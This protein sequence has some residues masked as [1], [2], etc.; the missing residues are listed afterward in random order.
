M[1]NHP[2]GTGPPA[3]RPA[4]PETDEAERAAKGDRPASLELH[5]RWLREAGLEP[6]V[7]DVTGH[8]VLLGARR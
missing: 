2:A 1:S 7:L 6:A 3:E 5:L 8:D 4:T